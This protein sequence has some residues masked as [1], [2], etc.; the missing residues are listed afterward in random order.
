MISFITPIAKTL[1]LS[2]RCGFI[3]EGAPCIFTGRLSK[4]ITVTYGASPEYKLF[5]L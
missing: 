5:N 4:H 2:R 3:I 1:F